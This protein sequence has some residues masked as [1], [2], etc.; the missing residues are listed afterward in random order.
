MYDV[1]VLNYDTLKKGVYVDVS[2]YLYI[3][4]IYVY[5]YMVHVILYVNSTGTT[6]SCIYAMHYVQI[7]TIPALS[8][9]QGKDLIV[10][11]CVRGKAEA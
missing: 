1:Y 7:C 10:P 2:I 9:A 5:M 11:I 4:L 6:H 3:Y 8:L